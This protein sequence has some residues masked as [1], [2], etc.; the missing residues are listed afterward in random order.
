MGKSLSTTL[1][2]ISGLITS[3]LHHSVL[4][5]NISARLSLVVAWVFLDILITFS[6]AIHLGPLPWSC[7]LKFVQTALETVRCC[8]KYGAERICLIPFS[9][10]YV[11]N[12][13]DVNWGSFY[14]TSCI[15]I[16]LQANISRISCIVC[17]SSAF[18]KR[19][20]R[21]FWMGVWRDKKIRS[22]EIAQQNLCRS[23]ATMNLAIPKEV[24]RYTEAY[25]ILFSFFFCTLHIIWLLVRYLGRSR[26]SIQLRVCAFIFTIPRCPLCS[27]FNNRF[28]IVKGIMIFI[29]QVSTLCEVDNSCL[30]LK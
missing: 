25:L 19:Y 28:R 17:G 11:A 3:S 21:P 30:F 15:C 26:A 1:H 8:I 5:M 7:V 12:S 14:E 13:S 2:S 23:V 18:Y 22:L 16:P 9:C 4:F 24:N 10:M 20:L 27:I 6:L 29:L